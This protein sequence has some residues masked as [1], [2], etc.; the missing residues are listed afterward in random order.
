MNSMMDSS[1]GFYGS[2]GKY[3]SYAEKEIMTK[4]V[5]SALSCKLN[6]KIE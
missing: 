2:R 3:I 1:I 4:A 5:C 6:P